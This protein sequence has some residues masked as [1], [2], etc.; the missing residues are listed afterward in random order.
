MSDMPEQCPKGCDTRD[1]PT[2]IGNGRFVCECCG[3]EFA[4]AEG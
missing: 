4:A 3:T 2:P 1:A